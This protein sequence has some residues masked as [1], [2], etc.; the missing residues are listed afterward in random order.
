LTSYFLLIFSSD[1]VFQLTML[2]ISVVYCRSVMSWVLWNLCLKLV[3]RET[4]YTCCC[5]S[6][7]WQ[8]CYMCSWQSKTIQ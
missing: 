2:A 3:A 5:L 4:R 6:Q 1:H 7:G 8:I